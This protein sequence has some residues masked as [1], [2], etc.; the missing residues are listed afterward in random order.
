M[1]QE[2]I[3]DSKTDTCIIGLRKMMG[4]TA[5]LASDNAGNGE[6]TFIGEGGC[7][8]SFS[9]HIAHNSFALDIGL[10]QEIE[11]M[12]AGA[13]MESRKRVIE[14]LRAQVKEAVEVST[15]W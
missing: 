9:P 4:I 2:A 7:K 11:T 8:F 10:S 13:S 3:L 1:S 5:L 14:K 12:I 6:G 15:N